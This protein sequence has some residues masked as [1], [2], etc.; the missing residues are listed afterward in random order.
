M[1]FNKIIKHAEKYKNSSGLL[2]NK[3]NESIMIN[4]E[5]CTSFKDLIEKIQVDSLIIEPEDGFSMLGGSRKYLSEELG[6]SQRDLY[7]WIMNGMHIDFEPN[8]SSLADWLRGTDPD[9]TI[10]GI[11]SRKIDGAIKGLV[12]TP[13]EG[14]SC[15]K[16]FAQAIYNKPYRDFFYNVTYESLYYA[17]HTLNSRS[18]AV[19]HLVAHKY[20]RYSWSSDITFCQVEAILHFCNSHKGIGSIVFWD[21]D[22]GNI[23]MRAIEQLLN[24]EKNS[25]HREISRSHEK[26]F[27][28]DF[29]SLDWPLPNNHI[30]NS[31]S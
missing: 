15:Y 11:P 24:K 2:I 25:Q 9:I 6:L 8:I 5:I 29:I 18:F 21:F 16:R 28:C 10:V 4:Q 19:S 1:Q 20:G 12:L 26:K 27:G 14:S 23:P 3:Y 31:K 7:N 17:Y 30:I 22:T 13:Y